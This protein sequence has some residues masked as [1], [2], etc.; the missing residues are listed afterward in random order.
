MSVVH[1]PPGMYTI[2]TT[3]YPGTFLTQHI[4]TPA[5]YRPTGFWPKPNLE[6]SLCRRDEEY[7]HFTNPGFSPSPLAT[8]TPN[9]YKIISA[10]HPIPQVVG[11]TAEGKEQNWAVEFRVLTGSNPAQ[12][13]KFIPPPENKA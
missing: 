13:W 11:Y 3:A 8:G 12:N 10:N 6:A 2:E 5:H 1:L 4:G 7:F 9:V